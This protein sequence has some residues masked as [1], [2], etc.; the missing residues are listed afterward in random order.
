[1]ALTATI[2]R[3]SVVL[4]LGLA[5]G[6]SSANKARIPNNPDPIIKGDLT[7]DKAQRALEMKLAKQIEFLDQNSE[8]YKDQVVALPSGDVT[9]YYKYYDMFPQGPDNV[10]ITI[11]PTDTFRPPYKAEARYRKVR[12]QTR[13]SR[14]KG[15]AAADTDFIRD[16]GIQKDVYVFDDGK[17]N[18]KSSTFDV[19]KTSVFR[20][21]EWTVAQG[22]I[23]RVEEEKPE[24]FVD[25]L[26]TLF[27]LLD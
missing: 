19:T 17:W 16:E 14:S 1:M 9:Y 23:R 27:G 6:C 22:R 2:R 5:I 7:E 21:D 25:K 13:Y 15:R 24:Y 10:T 20:G 18:L 8:R 4:L 3:S 11:T 26:R 12:Q